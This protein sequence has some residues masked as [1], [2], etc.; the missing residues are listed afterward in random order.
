MPTPNRL[1]ACLCLGALALS[2]GCAGLAGFEDSLESAGWAKFDRSSRAGRKGRV[3]LISQRGL[4][5]YSSG[6]GA[7]IGP[8]RVLT[9][10]H[11]VAGATRIE[12]EIDGVLCSVDVRVQRRIRAQPEDLVEL[13]LQVAPGVFG[14]RGFSPEQT[15]ATSSGQPTQLWARRGLFNLPIPSYPGDS[16]SPLLDAEGQL[17]GLL[18]G[19]LGGEPVWTPVPRPRLTEEEDDEEEEAPVYRQ[20]VL[21]YQAPTDHVDPGTSGSALEVN[22]ARRTDSLRRA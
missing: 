13:E 22:G 18:V 6:A 8:Q 1:L 7:A 17:V 9:V 12:A 4:G 10:A 16:G 15:F 19:T 11:V 20:S 3:N 14:F 21:T 2:S 5:D